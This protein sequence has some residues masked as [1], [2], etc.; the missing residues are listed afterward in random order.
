MHAYVRREKYKDWEGY[1]IVAS[2]KK[3]EL[4]LEPCGGWVYVVFAI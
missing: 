1:E 2:G 3:L 4:E